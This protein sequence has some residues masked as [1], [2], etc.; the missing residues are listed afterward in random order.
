MRHSVG[1]DGDG[2]CRR[3]GA[4]GGFDFRLAV[5][6]GPIPQFSED[7]DDAAK[8]PRKGRLFG[9]QFQGPAQ[10]LRTLLDDGD[11]VVESIGDRQHD[12]I[13]PPHQRTGEIVDPFI[14]VVGR[15]D[16]IETLGG[17]DLRIEFRHRQ[18]L[19]RKD[20]DQRVLHFT[21]NAGQFLDAA[22]LAGLHRLD[23]RAFDEG[24]A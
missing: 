4:A 8:F 17:L 9:G 10:L 12:R 21:G 11:F 20:R 23:H 5:F 6:G 7:G 1:N 2:L 13:K 18:G 16:D 19:F 22:D 3:K 15:R 24:I 14:A